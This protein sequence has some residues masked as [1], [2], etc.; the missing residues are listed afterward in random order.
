MKKT[1]WSKFYQEGLVV[2]DKFIEMIGDSFIRKA[3]RSED[4]K[5]HWDILCKHGKV[6]VKGMKK[7]NR[8][9]SKTNPDIHFYE[10]KNVEGK[11]GW[12]VPNNVKRMIAFESTE[13]FILVDPEDIYQPLID[14]CKIHKEGWG[15][16]QCRGREGRDDWFTKLPTEFLREYSCGIVEPVSGIRLYNKRD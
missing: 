16:F 13:G 4:G 8:S 3:T 11:S 5:E 10:F 2:E 1:D 9:D 12:G 7:A 15:F 6:D 14:K